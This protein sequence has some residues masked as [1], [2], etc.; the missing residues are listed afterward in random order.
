M[1]ASLGLKA[2]LVFFALAS[3]AGAGEPASQ[4]ITAFKLTANDGMTVASYDATTMGQIVMPTGSPWVCIVTP[5]TDTGGGATMAGF[6]CRLQGKP[7]DGQLAVGIG[8]YSSCEKAQVDHDHSVMVMQGG[9]MK[10]VILTTECV[11]VSKSKQPG[12]PKQTPVAP[13]PHDVKL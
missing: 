6:T 2:A 10:P 7:A 5:E 12:G 1:K 13:N 8:T 11:T 9:R 4:Y 3:T